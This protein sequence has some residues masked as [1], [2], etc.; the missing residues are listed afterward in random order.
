MM[1]CPLPAHAQA[2]KQ[3]WGHL[4]LDWLATDRLTYE[5]RIEPKVQP[6]G[7]G[8]EA[9]WISLSTTPIVEYAVSAWVDV[10]AESDIGYTKQSNN[11]DTLR[12]TS[13]VG[14][15]LHIFS[16]I[17]QRRVRKGA[18]REKHPNRR[19]NITTLVRFE[20]ENT[21]RTT[22]GTP[23]KSEWQ[24]RSRSELAYPLNRLQT[25]ADGA[26]YVKSDGE[27]F[28]PVDSAVDGGI[29]S[30]V[31]LRAGVGYRRS[32]AWRFEALYVW[33]GERNGESGVMAPQSHAVQVRLRRQF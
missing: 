4:A 6:F 26:I 16:R 5:L 15:H 24:V 28:F 17:M 31:R 19:T 14:V 8:D 9:T 22:D 12:V 29:V 32:F 23:V 27:L 20:N 13:R 11:A 21:F 18:A 1:A 7:H 3:L 33:T 10:R 30:Q 2:T 25:T